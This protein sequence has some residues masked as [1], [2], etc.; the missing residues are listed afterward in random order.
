MYIGIPQW[1]FPI[2][3]PL[4]QCTE[5]TFPPVKQ[6]IK[7]MRTNQ[8]LFVP[9]NMCSNYVFVHNCTKHVPDMYQKYNKQVLKYTTHVYLCICLCV[10]IIYIHFQHSENITSNCFYI[11][12]CLLNI[13]IYIYIYVYGEYIYIYI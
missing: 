12:I 3:Y 6:V 1:L 4:Y 10:Y 13:F 7:T 9:Q 11:Y 2:I 8:L 5:K